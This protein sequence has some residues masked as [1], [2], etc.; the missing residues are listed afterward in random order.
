MVNYGLPSR[1]TIPNLLRNN[2]APQQK[3][4]TLQ[5]HFKTFSDTISEPVGIVSHDLKVGSGGSS[6]GL[7]SL[8]SAAAFCRRGSPGTRRRVPICSCLFSARIFLIR[9]AGCATRAVDERGNSFV[10]FFFVVFWRERLFCRIFFIVLREIFASPRLSSLS[11]L[12]PSS[13]IVKSFGP[14]SSEIISGEFSN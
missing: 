14:R 12:E 1:E 5:Y 11:L 8:L 6:K 3:Q 2:I 9:K 7:F 10:G 13:S 4:S